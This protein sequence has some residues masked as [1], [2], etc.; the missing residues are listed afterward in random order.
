M[1][2]MRPMH[3][4]RVFALCFFTSYVLPAL[5]VQTTAEQ[6]RQAFL[7]IIDRPKVALS[8][9]EKAMPAAAGLTEIY[10]TYA[11]DDQLR[12]PGI[13]LKQSG[14]AQKLPV[15]IVAH[16]TGGK[17]EGQFPLMNQL[18]AKGFLA[19]AIDGRYHGERAG[20][21]G[22]AAY[23]GAVARAF[24]EGGE[25][26]F[27]YDTVWDLMRLVDYLQTR[28]DVDAARIG[29]IGFSK[30]GIETY[31]AAA[32][33]PRFAVAVPCIGVQSF[34]WALENDAWRP[35]IATIQAGANEAAKEAGVTTLDAAFIRRFYD[36]VTPGIYSDFDGPVMV[37]LIAPRPLLVI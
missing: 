18:V 22:K 15:V 26:P 30:G 36:K 37:T 14:A 19:V 9:V 12:V 24:R 5:A 17:K 2:D 7:K 20:D 33:D 34:G 13:L 28:P 8:P 3:L 16:G 21:K 29:I 35:R 31:L 25:H 4:A 32:V 11:A 10:F 27:Y 6:T 1:P 23:N